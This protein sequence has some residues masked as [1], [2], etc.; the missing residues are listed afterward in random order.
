M[1]TLADNKKQPT[2][3]EV[4]KRPKKVNVLTVPQA[5]S[6]LPDEVLK[7]KLNPRQVK[8][9][10]AYCTNGFNAG[11]A[12]RMAGYYSPEKQHYSSWAIKTLKMPNVQEAIQIFIDDMIAPYKARLEFQV[13][14]I[15]YMRAVFKVSTFYND[16]G[17]LK[18]LNE[19]PERWQVCIDGISETITSLKSGGYVRTKHYRLA[20][21]DIAL[22]TLYRMCVKFMVDD[23][24]VGHL[25]E[26]ARTRLRKIFETAAP[27]P[28]QNSLAVTITNIVQQSKQLKKKVR[29]LPSD[30]HII[31]EEK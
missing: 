8:F 23:N 11:L 19:I 24:D 18:P 4:A 15:Y 26:E 17:T 30:A 14:E 3:A 1:K 27:G 31:K 22:Q 21:R 16:D 9:V 6:Y 2:I 20:D 28:T 13:L 25:P 12:A 10:A 5:K 7:I 29:Q